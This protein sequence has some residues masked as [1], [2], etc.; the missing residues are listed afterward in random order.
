MSASV[1]DN[2]V[3]VALLDEDNGSLRCMGGCGV[4]FGG[5]SERV[6]EA[7]QSRTSL[8]QRMLA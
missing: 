1:H 7:E 2:Q 3:F 4:S 8:A 5:E 6:E